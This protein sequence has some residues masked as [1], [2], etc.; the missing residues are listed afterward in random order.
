MHF[1]PDFS[2]FPFFTIQEGTS[3]AEDYANRGICLPSDTQMTQG[4][5]DRVVNIVKQLFINS[6]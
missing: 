2:D 1:Q 3:I 5:Q 4:E 6:K